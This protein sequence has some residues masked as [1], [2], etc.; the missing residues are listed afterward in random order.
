MF[1]VNN[2][3]RERHHWHR[4]DV[5]TVNFEHVSN[6][7]SCVSV[8]DFEQ[9]KVSWE[10]SHL[11]AGIYLLKVNNRN[12]KTRCKICS[13]LTSANV[14]FMVSLSLTLNIFHTLV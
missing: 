6:L 8:V 4:S 9:I 14:V 5:F 1:K 13:K 12:T 7:F 11:P 3:I 2:K 10:G